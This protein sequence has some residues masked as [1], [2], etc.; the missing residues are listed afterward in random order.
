M[1]GFCDGSKNYKKFFMDSLQ[2][3]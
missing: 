1:F 2:N 3:T